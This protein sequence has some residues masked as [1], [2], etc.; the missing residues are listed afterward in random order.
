MKRLLT[1]G[2][3]GMT[4]LAAAAIAANSTISAAQPGAKDAVAMVEHGAAYMKAHGKDALIKKIKARSPDFVHGSLYLS[5]RDINTG[6]LLA[7]PIKP[8]LVGKNLLDVGDAN[9]KLYRSE[10]II[11]ARK[12]GKGWV[13]YLYEN[14]V[15][16]KL[17][18]KSTYLVRFDDVVLEAGIYK[19]PAG[20]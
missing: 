8:S 1:G 20:K 11:M 16:G 9:G 2:L 4:I 14:P 10:I 5:M 13:D 3:L 19:K 12:Q 6:M 18:P 17:E 7:H 15:S